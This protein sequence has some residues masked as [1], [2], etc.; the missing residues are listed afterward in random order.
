MPRFEW[1]TVIPKQT[2]DVICLALPWGTVRHFPVPAR[3][4]N[5]STYQ[6]MPWVKAV[7]RFHQTMWRADTMSHPVMTTAG[8]SAMLFAMVLICA[9]RVEAAHAPR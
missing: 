7:Q 1:S 4:P 2:S 5:N 3:N 9:Y 8:S 6:F